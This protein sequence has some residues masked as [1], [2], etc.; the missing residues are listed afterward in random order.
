MSDPYVERESG[1]FPSALPRS[2]HRAAADF[3]VGTRVRIISPMVDFT[4]FR[5]DEKG[6]VIRNGN[7][8]L[9][10]IVEFDEPMRYE[11]GYVKTE[12]GFEPSDLIIEG[13]AWSPSRDEP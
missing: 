8:Y 12:H 5:G 4:W 2:H 6:T 11:G 3:P 7:R 13:E 10:I 9:S 1:R